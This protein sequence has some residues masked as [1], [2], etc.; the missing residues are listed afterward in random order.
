MNSTLKVTQNDI[1]EELFL[2]KRSKQLIFD[3]MHISA[4]ELPQIEKHFTMLF[5]GYLKTEN[6]DYVEE[7]KEITETFESVMRLLDFLK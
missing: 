6:A 4:A 3:E 1:T 2:P 7:R 5:T